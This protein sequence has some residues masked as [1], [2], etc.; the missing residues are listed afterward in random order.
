MS[1]P[2]FLLTPTDRAWR[3]LR[4]ITLRD[5]VACALSRYGHHAVVEIGDG[6]F[7]L[8]AEGTYPVLNWP[9][10]DPRWPT[11]CACGYAFQP[12]DY[13][14]CDQ[15][16][17]FHTPDGRACGTHHRL[18]GT[19]RAAPAG[20]MWVATWVPAG[21][22]WS[23]PDGRCLVVM[24]PDGMEWMID[25]RARSG[26]RWTRTGEPPAITARPSI[27]SPGY[28]GWLTAGV[29]SDDLEGRTYE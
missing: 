26:G 16:L 29:L 13:W 9:K 6:P 24:L 10:D 11:H 25:G 21:D 17:I 5:T 28:H 19:E 3:S 2:C 14:A 23:G 7:A 22:A 8:T 15:D 4:R 12:E 1:W 18:R 20:A 27:A